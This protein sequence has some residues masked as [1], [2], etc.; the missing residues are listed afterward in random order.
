MTEHRSR[1]WT[2]VALGGLLVLALTARPDAA[3]L[4]QHLHAH[5][6]TCDGAEHVGVDIGFGP[7]AAPVQIVATKL[8]L[9]GAGPRWALLSRRSDDLWLAWA[10]DEGPLYTFAKEVP[11]ASLTLA[12]GDRIVLTHHCLPPASYLIYAIV[13]Y[14]RP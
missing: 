7:F 2:G 14:V 11:A 4:R 6:G 9:A 12:A 1:G 5:Q 13:E 3:D 8:V 10:H